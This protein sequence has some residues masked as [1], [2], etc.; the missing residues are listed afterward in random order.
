MR[1]FSEELF[2]ILDTARDGIAGVSAQIVDHVSF[3][4]AVPE[5]L[6]MLFHVVRATTPVINRAVLRAEEHGVIDPF[7]HTLRDFYKLKLKEET[8]H[9]VM[10]CKDLALVGISELDLEREMPPAGVVA[11]V[12]SQYYLMDFCHP[13]AYLGYLALL[14]GYPMAAEQLERLI[15]RSGI[16]AKAW[17]T[18]RMHAQVDVHHRRELE[19]VL[20]NVREDDT[21]LR[22]LVIANGL[23]SAEYL[24]QSLEGILDNLNRETPRAGNV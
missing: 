21:H 9:D 10:F 13:G 14:E 15:E 7:G 6:G 16:P 8:G 24:C 20:D 3:P 12:G 4:K 22:N 19:E 23:R 1:R 5:W 17:S 11:L 2:E 18:Y